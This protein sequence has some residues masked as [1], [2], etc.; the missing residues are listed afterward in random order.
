MTG[1]PRR[2]TVCGRVHL[3]PC[4][5]NDLRENGT[6]QPTCQAC[7][8]VLTQAE[9]IVIQRMWN[10]VRTMLAPYKREKQR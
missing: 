4:C 6:R 1:H 10:T 3:G 9:R 7:G 5:V 8:V 2:I